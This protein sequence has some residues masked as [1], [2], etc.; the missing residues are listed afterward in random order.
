MRIV[1]VK[2]V[3]K[4]I[5][6]LA[7]VDTV[8]RHKD[9]RFTDMGAL[10]HHKA[11]SYFNRQFKD[12][13]HALLYESPHYEIPY[14]LIPRLQ[15][16]DQRD[17]RELLRQYQWSED[18]KQ[19]YHEGMKQGELVDKI[20]AGDIDTI[21][22][23]LEIA[24]LDPNNF[25][26]RSEVCAPLLQG[27]YTSNDDGTYPAMAH[28]Q[29]QALAMYITCKFTNNWG[30]MRTGKTPPTLIYI[31]WLLATHQ[32]DLA[33][34]VVPNSIKRIWYNEI[35]LDMP[36]EILHMTD[37][38]EG[39]KKKK[40]ELWQK[41]SFIKIVNYEGLRADIIEAT[42]ALSDRKFLLVLD[43]AHNVKNPDSKQ[44]VAIRS[45]NPDF[46]AA[47]SGTP[48]ANKP[49]DVFIPVH[50]TCPNLI[51]WSFQSF[52]QEF[53][54]LGGYSGTDISGY[55]EGALPEIRKRMG[56][57]SIRALRKDVG[58]GYG[59]IIQPAD[60]IMSPEVARLHK[61]INSQF[62][63]ELQSAGMMTQIKITGFLARLVR[64]QQ[65]VDGY[66]PIIKSDGSQNGQVLWV[67][68]K[69]NA[70]IQWIDKF[71]KDYLED[72]GKV[73]IFS[74]FI[75]VIKKLASR[76]AFYGS[77]YICGEVK[78]DERAERVDKF[79]S[80]PACKVLVVNLDIAAGMDM[81]P[82]DLPK[83]A[84]S[85][86]AIFY[87]RSWYYMPNVQAE[88]RI[89]GF[90]Q[91]AESTI[92]PLVCRGSIDERLVKVLEK[93]RKC[94]EA[95]IGGTDVKTVDMTEG[96]KITQQDLFDLVGV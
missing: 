15:H 50:M 38:I 91:K 85:Q 62:K 83:T 16:P 2:P 71:L 61:E 35:P 96:L 31:Y 68:D 14:P 7:I 49:Q 79:R 82:H 43:E 94:A 37:I 66:L 95:V 25:V 80:D 18:A 30:Q 73:V 11:L 55:Q 67:E 48:V 63:V 93:K 77:T 44:T 54:K 74:R 84:N 1:T 75:P 88:D 41:K 76:Y 52:K 89:T 70:K 9:R 28:H 57:I 4:Q 19:L 40:A 39:S 69:D 34:C 8:A 56:R 72:L 10:Y 65:A 13:E 53:C 21:K 24:G 81:N 5:T 86:V 47:L 87:E 78:P 90:N 36:K 59:K 27:Y 64:L 42:R 17:L 92:I 22:S 33:L 58:I 45:L 3:N 32:I 51:G 6:N 60:L 20:K 29:L 12:T 23:I 46:F 26:R